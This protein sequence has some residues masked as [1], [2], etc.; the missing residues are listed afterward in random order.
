MRF[1]CPGFKGPFVNLH[2]PDKPSVRQVLLMTAQGVKGRELPPTPLA[3]ESALSPV[4]DES[5]NANLVFR[6]IKHG[7]KSTGSSKL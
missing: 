3:C 5:Q 2:V 7:H 6:N 4:S 1:F